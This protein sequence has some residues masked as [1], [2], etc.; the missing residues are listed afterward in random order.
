MEGDFNTGVSLLIDLSGSMSGGKVQTAARVAMTFAEALQSV[1]MIKFEILGYN[2]QGQNIL[3]NI[4]HSDFN[5][6]EKINHW[7]FK[8]FNEPWRL[9]S[10]RMGSV[11]DSLNKNG[12]VGGC[13]ID[14][15]NLNL[16]AKRLFDQNVHKRILIVICDGIPN[17]GHGGGYNH[18]LENELK[19]I[20]KKIR[21]HNIKLFCFGINSEKVK[22][23]Y[24]PEV[25]ILQNIED[26]NKVALNQLAKYML[27]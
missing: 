18:L 9:V 21:K 1:P 7:I 10:S 25:L 23:F 27:D 14:H 26:L 17:G 8:S 12:C 11:N 6:T 20:I 2:C 24:E 22:K 16:A 19:A 4:S 5:R 13:N 3:S 15:E